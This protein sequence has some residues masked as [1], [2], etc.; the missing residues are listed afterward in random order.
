MRWL[1][2]GTGLQ[3]GPLCHAGS[4]ACPRLAAPRKCTKMHRFH[5]RERKMQHF[6]TKSA[7][8]LAIPEGDA[9]PGTRATRRDTT[10][11]CGHFAALHAVPAVLPALRPRSGC[12]RRPETTQT[13]QEGPQGPPM[14]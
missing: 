12:G 5:Q 8:L 3:T 10:A 6:V 4:G 7:L 11:R 1:A 9:R 13:T 2:K 14:Q